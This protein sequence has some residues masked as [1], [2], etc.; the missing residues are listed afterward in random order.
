MEKHKN[1]RK[2]QLS[3]SNTLSTLKL[4]N[5]LKLHVE[6]TCSKT[7]SLSRKRLFQMFGSVCANVE[8]HG[9]N[10]QVNLRKRRARDLGSADL[11]GEP[12]PRVGVL[13]SSWGTS[14]VLRPTKAWACELSL[15]QG[16]SLDY[17]AQHP[18]LGTPMCHPPPSLM[19]G[20]I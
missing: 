2:L 11:R 13:L 5:N 6:N 14:W 19:R 15:I 10:N 1:D 17:L 8:K 16:Q 4:R 12:A 3:T 7:E 9:Q 20:S 18:Q